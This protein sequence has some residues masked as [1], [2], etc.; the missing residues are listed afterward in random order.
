M[1]AFYKPYL[2]DDSDS[3]TDSDGYTSEESLLNVPGK[4]PPVQTGMAA[5]F[6]DITPITSGGGKFEFKESRNTTLFTVNSRDRDATLYPQPTHFTIRLPRPFKNVASVNISQLNLL[7][8]FFNFTKNGGNTYMDVYEVGRTNK[9]GDSNITTV[10]IRDGS[11]SVDDLVNEL[12]NAMNATPLFADITLGDFI[13]GFQ[14]TG[15]YTLLFNTPG[16]VVYDSLTQTYDSNQTIQDIV[17]RYFQIAK[18]LGTLN[19]TYVECLVAYYYPVMKEMIITNNPNVPFTTPALPPGYSSWYDYL[20]FAFT[21]LD[22][23]YVTQILNSPSYGAANQ[24]IFDQYRYQNTFNT[25]LVNKYNCSYNARQ[26]R[27]NITAPSLNPSIQNDLNTQYN[28]YLNSLVIQS[29]QFTDV[30]DFNNQYS[31][32]SYS[33]SVALE[34]YNFIQSRFMSNFAVNFGQYTASF[35]GN[36]NNNIQLYSPLNRFGWNTTLSPA[37]SESPIYSNA[38]PSQVSTLWENIVINKSLI[39]QNS[40]VSTLT[41][42]QFSFGQLAFSNSGE[43]Q[44]GYTDIVFTQQPTSYN[45]IRFST[46]CRQDISIMTIPRYIDSRESSTNMVYNLGSTLTQTSRLYDVRTPGKT[47]ILTDISGNVSFNMFSVNQSM[48]SSVDYMRSL[49]EWL[50]PDNLTPQILAGTRI[51]STDINFNKQA[52]SSDLS[53]KS[54]RPFIFFQV[55]AAEYPV[56]PNARFNIRFY[57]ETQDSSLFGT[58][59]TVTWYRDRAGF[60]ADVTNLLSGNFNADDPRNYFVS[61]TTT[62]NRDISGAYMEVPVNNAQATYFSIHVQSANNL[63]SSIPIRVFALL[64]DNYGEYTIAS[65]EDRYDMPFSSI[66][67]SLAEQ[68]NTPYSKVFQN[69]TKSIYST[70]IFQLGYDISGV[71]NNFLDYIIQS[72][73][74]NYFYDPNN[75]TDYLNGSSTGLRYYFVDETNGS[76]QPPPTLSNTWSLYF[77]S[78][79]SNAIYD[80]YNQDGTTYLSA[81]QAPSSLVAGM[82]NEFLLVNWF[83][84]GATLGPYE[85]FLYPNV[86]SE[87]YSQINISS[88]FI[89]C[90]NTPTTN[91]DMAPPDFQDISGFCGMSFFLPPNQVVKLDSFLIK[92]AYTQPSSDPNNINY[93]RLNSPLVSSNNVFYNQCSYQNRTSYIQSSNSASDWDDWYLYNRRN[94]KLGVFPTASINGANVSSLQLSNALCT[95]TLDKITQVNSYQNQSGTLLTREPEWGTYYTYNIETQPTALWDVSGVTFSD[96]SQFYWYSTLIAPADFAP[97]YTAGN[98][99][100][101]SFFL[102]HAQ[103]FNYTYLPRTYG[104]SPAVGNATY[105]TLPYASTYTADIPNSYTIVPFYNDPATSNWCIGSFYGVSYTEQPALP[106]TSIA[107]SAPYAG[108]PGGFG[109]MVQPNSTIQMVSS[110]GSLFYWNTKIQYETVDLQYDPATDLSDFGGYEGI[111]SEYQDTM[112]FFY[113][114]TSNDA[115]FNDISFTRLTQSYWM[116]G[117]ESNSKYKYFDDNNGYNFLSY[118]HDKPLSTTVPEYAIHVRAY[119]PI[120]QFTTGIRFIGKNYTDFGTPTLGEIATEISSL[121]GYTPISDALAGTYVNNLY[122]T[123]TNG[124]PNYGPYAS[125]ISANDAIRLGNGNYFSHEYADALIAF[126]QTFST[127]VL[128]GLKVGYTGVPFTFSSFSDCLNQYMSFYSTTQA[129]LTTYTT[130]LSTATGELSD[131]TTI[132]YGNILPSSVLTR[133]RIT[134]PLTFQLLL[135]TS[136]VQPY[137][138]QYDQWGLGWNLGFNKRDTPPSVSVTSDTFIRI[139]QDYIYLQLNPEFNINSVAVSGKEDRSMCLDSAGQEAK[140]FSKIILNDFASYC[141]TAVQQAKQFNPVLGKYETLSCQLVDKNGNN[142]SSID[143]EYDFVLE[144]TEIST[145]PADTA[146]LLTTTADLNVYSSK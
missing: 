45:R 52:A 9:F 135:S 73:N 119:D 99:S 42:P 94:T 14:A 126:E 134:D 115:D 100:Y 44:L 56:E 83:K 46:R 13:N 123:M 113:K 49:N 23:P 18:T 85:R 80:S 140:Y 128:F 97:T 121:A 16:N 110:V 92:F 11:Y 89:P 81:S 146:S 106:S 48:F 26:G 124:L 32:I 28:F 87:Y 136:L 6:G 133:N 65:V 118:L 39:T 15:D 31:A 70:S 20:V 22:D 41:V 68:E 82:T 59:L 143:C 111:Q 84:A 40:F 91:T 76:T 144:V 108:P 24:A 114:N 38:I 120:P 27:L 58:P 10:K 96:P 4:A 139:V 2:S 3:E 109:W 63:P 105:T 21:G 54:Y 30:N 116:W 50:N 142:I 12:T 35:F 79:S 127:S 107:G 104:I 95:F 64:A 62:F 53:L 103:I 1:A 132:R 90:I 61:D 33:N 34:L 51:Q 86:N 122:S 47:F 141:R 8:S 55:N 145:K 78:N 72:Q 25:A 37:V 36:S 138:S 131:Y 69:P 93:T 77:G 75:I 117:Q 74:F 101:S 17:A 5:Q 71:S 129:S 7:N 57:I 98:M 137:K 29:G 102:T 43:S 130:I 112:L 88:I 60:M 19:F 66:L 125:T 67:F